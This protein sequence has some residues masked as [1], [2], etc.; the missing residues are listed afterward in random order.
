MKNLSK[1]IF[2]IP[3]FLLLVITVWIMFGS[4]IPLQEAYAK[5]GQLHLDN[6]NRHS[7][8]KL[9]GE[10]QYYESNGR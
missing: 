3:T 8:I 2:W 6:W 9:K 1:N 7:L 5:K 10:W 4:S